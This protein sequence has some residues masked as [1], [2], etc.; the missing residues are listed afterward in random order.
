MFMISYKGHQVNGGWGTLI[1]LLSPA[2]C[3]RGVM[4][5]GERTEGALKQGNGC[6]WSLS[7]PQ[8][9]ESSMLATLGKGQRLLLKC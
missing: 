6:L 4:T 7:Q 2:S 3:F 5:G 9:M 1:R 8:A